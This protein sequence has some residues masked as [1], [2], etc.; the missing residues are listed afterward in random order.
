MNI[1]KIRKLFKVLL[2]ELV[3]VSFNDSETINKVFGRVKA[4][5]PNNVI[6]ELPIPAFVPKQDEKISIELNILLKDVKEIKCFC[7]IYQS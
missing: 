4:V 7:S 3:E 2:L 6:I 5:L 1:D